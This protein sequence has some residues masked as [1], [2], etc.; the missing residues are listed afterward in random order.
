[1]GDANWGLIIA[2]VIVVLINIVGLSM[3]RS[4]R[5]KKEKQQLK[6]LKVKLAETKKELNIYKAQ[7]NEHF[8]K[9]NVL[10]GELTEKYQAVFKHLSEG[11]QEMCSKD[12]A[13]LKPD[14]SK[15]A[16]LAQGAED[17]ES[18]EQGDTEAAPVDDEA[19]TESPE[20]ADASAMTEEQ[21][22][23]AGEEES[24][25]VEQEEEKVAES[26]TEETV[27]EEPAEEA[28]ETDQ[29]AAAEEPDKET[30]VAE[31]DVIV[32]V[33]A[34]EDERMKQETTVEETDKVEVPEGPEWE[35]NSEDFTQDDTETVAAEEAAG[36]AVETEE[37]KEK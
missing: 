1:M 6:E 18:T 19:K 4:K 27:V 28:V 8:M 29:E 35:T 37:K 33:K 20:T 2:V 32:E 15:F 25:P 9:T 22:T 16:V 24:Q 31:Q 11:S 10:F 30:V 5:S 14:D 3:F 7:V 26:A 34:D 36:A 17:K 23:E 12:T 21:K 13:M